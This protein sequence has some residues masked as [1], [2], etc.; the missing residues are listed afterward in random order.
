MSLALAWA[1]SAKAAAESINLSEKRV[2]LISLNN[3]PMSCLINK[4]AI[5]YQLTF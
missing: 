3:C 4:R 1:T 5:L 2:I